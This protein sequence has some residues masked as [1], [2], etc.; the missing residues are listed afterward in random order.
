MSGDQLTILAVDDERTQL[1]DLAR[2]LRNSPSVK[3]VECATRPRRAGQGLDRGLRRDLPRRPDARPRRPRARARAPALRL[4]APAGV[5]PAHEM[6]RSTH[7]SCTRSITY[8]SRLAAGGSRRRSSA[9]RPPSTSAKRAPRA[10]S[11]GGRGAGDDR[12][13]SS[14]SRTRTGLDP[15][16]RAPPR[17]LIVQSHG[18]F[19]RIVTATGATCSEGR[20][21]TSSAGGAHGFVR[22]HRQYVANLQRGGAAPAARRHRRADLLR[23]SDDSGGQYGHTGERGPAALA[24]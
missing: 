10:R 16:A 19:V 13:R 22:V 2:L 20:S 11:A 24:C 14:R 5:R 21:A 9:S 18:D 8:S 3:E 1:E 15:P 12:A 23:R 6:R 4:A 7:S 17:S